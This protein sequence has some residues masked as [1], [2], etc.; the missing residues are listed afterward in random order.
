MLRHG[1]GAPLDLDPLDLAF[2]EAV[3]AADL[4]TSL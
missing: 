4:I 2:L 3:L 1:P